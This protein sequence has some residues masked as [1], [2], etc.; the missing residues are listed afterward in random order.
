MFGIRRLTYPNRAR[1]ALRDC[2]PEALRDNTFLHVLQAEDNVKQWMAQLRAN[3]QGVSPAIIG[4]SPSQPSLTSPPLDTQLLGG[5]GQLGGIHM[6][7]GGMGIP[8]VTSAFQIQGQAADH[9]S[10]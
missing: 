9:L 3:L 8:M 10:K 2:L 6:E 4:Q 1:D 7:G 5:H